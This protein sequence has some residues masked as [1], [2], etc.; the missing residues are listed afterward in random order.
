MLCVP[1]LLIGFLCV[2]ALPVCFL[3]QRVGNQPIAEVIVAEGHIIYHDIARQL[4]G[5]Q[6]FGILV[7]QKII[8]LA[9]RDL[10]CRNRCRGIIN[11][12]I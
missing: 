10:E 6:R 12:P 7:C 8:E 2:E 5:N 3:I 1:L 9:V 11:K 4:E